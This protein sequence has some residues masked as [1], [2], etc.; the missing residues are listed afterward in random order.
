MGISLLHAQ[1]GPS[2]F[3]LR[4]GLSI[5]FGK[6]SNYN[7]Q[8]SSFTTTGISISGD[9]AWFFLPYLG[10]GGEFD[11][12]LQPIDVG[13]L[14]YEK[15]LADPALEDVTIRSEGFQTLTT[16]VG[17]YSEWNFWKSF[18]LSGKLLG[19]WIWAKTPYQLY[20]PVY[21][22]IGAAD[23]Y[24]ITSAKDNG[25]IIIPGIGLQHKFS[26]CIALKAEGELYYRNMQFGYSRFGEVYYIDRR[27]SF[28]NV[29]LGLVVLL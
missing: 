13:V 11:Y 24:E 19:G 8:E 20:K 2:Y 7:L 23:W 18:S 26:H 17:L 1:P 27:V 5:P 3:A 12:N 22:M 14:G 15:V 4:T 10:V 16:G 6:F 29:T 21:F 28:I 25:F 9:G